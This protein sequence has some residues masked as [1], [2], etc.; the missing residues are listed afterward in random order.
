MPIRSLL[1]PSFIWRLCLFSMLLF[2]T[3]CGETSSDKPSTGGSSTLLTTPTPHQ[4]DAFSPLNSGKAF[5]VEGLLHVQSD[6]GINCRI[7]GPVNSPFPTTVLS[8][9]Q[10]TYDSGRIQQLA[11][12]FDAV[13]DQ[14][15]Q[16]KVALPELPQG[17]SV[18]SATPASSSVCQGVLEVTNISQSSFQLSKVDI[19]LTQAAQPISH[20]YPL[21]DVCS[22]PIK[23]TTQCPPIIGGAPGDYIYS[24]NLEAKNAGETFHGKFTSMSGSVPMLNPG[25][26]IFLDLELAST[27]SYSYSFI[28]TL[29]IDTPG[30]QK[31]LE[32]AQLDS[33]LAF[34]PMSNITCL[35]LQNTTFVQVE[36]SQSDKKRFCV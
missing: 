34:I 10:Q 33:I 5:D 13:H 1:L 29:T 31:S 9:Q 20:P 27:E 21:I 12:Y 23:W 2:A 15:T 22:L 3:G 8:T 6:K 16:P 17:F 26:A 32:L 25:Q 28:P 4:T 14:L 24:F 19:R 30:T 35:A 11:T 7:I 18:T 36:W